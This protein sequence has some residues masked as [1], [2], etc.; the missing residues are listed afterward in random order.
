MDEM[1]QELATLDVLPI[2]ATT[3]LAS[4]I[5]PE[6]T[7]AGITPQFLSYSLYTINEDETRTP[8]YGDTQYGAI[9]QIQVIAGAM[10]RVLPQVEITTF[11]YSYDD[12]NP[13]QIVKT[14]LSGAA[15]VNPLNDGVSGQSFTV[16]FIT[17]TL[18][19]TVYVQFTDSVVVN[20]SAKWFTAEEFTIDPTTTR[21]T[22]TYNEVADYSNNVCWFRIKYIPTQQNTGSFKK[23]ILSR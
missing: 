15:D 13:S 3:G 6:Q 20:A 1:S 2:P 16:D 17:D 21:I 19:A 4:C 11:N 12:S 9:G 18:D 23:V 22:K 5:I 8:M 7:I 14:Y 10:P